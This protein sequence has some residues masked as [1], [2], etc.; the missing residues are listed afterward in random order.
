M[1]LHNFQAGVLKAALLALE[2]VLGR[3][4]LA[5]CDEF[6]GHEWVGTGKS[7]GGSARYRRLAELGATDAGTRA[8]AD[9]S[10]LAAITA[11]IA[12][13]TL[14]NGAMPSGVT[15]LPAE[16]AGGLREFRAFVDGVSVR[17]GP[18]GCL[19]AAPSAGSRGVLVAS[20]CRPLHV[21]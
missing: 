18:C 5:G 15:R 6:A 4:G 3:C 9:L 1:L 10:C 12:V 17:L 8:V 7:A 14:S 19:L 20:G 16:A 11:A 13:L 21:C 2:A